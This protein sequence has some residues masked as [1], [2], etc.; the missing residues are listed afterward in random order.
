MINR[1]VL[2]D[3]QTSDEKIEESI[4]LYFSKKYREKHGLFV[5]AFAKKLIREQYRGE[6]EKGAIAQRRAMDDAGEFERLSDLK[7]PVLFVHGDE[8]AV[9]NIESSRRA[10]QKIASSTLVEFK[11]AGHML[12]VEEPERL[13]QVILDYISLRLVQ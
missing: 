9:V 4:P 2:F 1:E 8:D 7:I 6:S 10:H 3:L 12:L 13:F 5:S 11:E